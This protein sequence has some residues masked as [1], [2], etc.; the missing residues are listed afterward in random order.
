MQPTAT[1]MPSSGLASLPTD[2][3]SPPP[4]S[5]LPAAS[6]SPLLGPSD[7]ETWTPARPPAAT[8]TFAGS[9]TGAQQLP[10]G[11]STLPSDL[12]AIMSM[13]APLGQFAGPAAN[14]N[15]ESSKP[16][17]SPPS[18]SPSTPG[19]GSLSL[20][21]GP[22]QSHSML[23]VAS[24]QAAASAA[25]PDSSLPP[26]PSYSS[27]SGPMLAGH[28]LSG[29]GPSGG[30][31]G[32][33][34]FVS[35]RTVEEGVAVG[36]A[37]G[38]GGSGGSASMSMSVA[39]SLRHPGPGKSPSARP[40]TSTSS[41]LRPSGSRIGD[42]ETASQAAFVSEALGGWQSEPES[43]GVSSQQLRQKSDTSNLSGQSMF[44]GIRS[45]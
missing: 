13:S 34:G 22:S 41:R 32:G 10:S 36:G 3:P 18:K 27:S 20:P 33:G 35:S 8:W 29:L 45:K 25:G 2:R 19:S 40:S 42:L 11:P 31:S 14:Y 43:R 24:T 21:L 37:G 1:A 9:D 30:P 7:V 23:P 15:Q 16:R 26:R 5:S 28:S 4:R 38:G 39:A 6:S 12:G 44:G 17:S